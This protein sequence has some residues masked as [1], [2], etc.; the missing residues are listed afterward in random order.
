MIFESPAQTIVNLNASE[1]KNKQ[2]ADVKLFDN[3]AGNFLL[4]LKLTFHITKDNLLFMIVGDER[5]IND[6]K[7][8]W[9]FDE[10]INIK[11]LIK[12]NKNLI[13]S[14]EF[15]KTHSQV[16][17]ILKST[18]NVGIYMG[19][20]NNYEFVRSAPKPVFFKIKDL[21]VPVELKLKFYVSET[22]DKDVY[23]QILTAEAGTAKITI[24]IIK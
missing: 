9:M 20:Q 24:N 19:F 8:V 1:S 21:T 17:P 11:E 16:E 2:S 18:G 10:N 14:K 23:S 13:P 12:K 4:D 15:K 5:G 3:Y 7:T 6:F 22:S